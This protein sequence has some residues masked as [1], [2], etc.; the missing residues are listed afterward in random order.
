M[1]EE[2]PRSDGG[3]FEVQD[4]E[5]GDYEHPLRDEVAKIYVA[6]AG[7]DP[8]RC[9]PN[10]IEGESNVTSSA[11]EESQESS[12]SLR[13]SSVT[14]TTTREEPLSSPS[15]HGDYELSEKDG[16]F[17]SADQ[18]LTPRQ[19]AVRGIRARKMKPSVRKKIYGMSKQLCSV[20]LT[21]AVAVGGIAE[22]VLGEPLE[23]LWAVFQASHHHQE[24]PAC[25]EVFAGDCAISSAFA[26]KRMGVLRPRDLRYGDDLR[27]QETRNEVLRVV[28]ETRPTLV[29]MAPPCTAW[30]AFSRMNFSD[31][32]RRRRRKAEQPF[33]ELVDEVMLLQK[34]VGGHVVVENPATSDIWK[35]SRLRK[36]CDDERVHSFLLDMCYFGMK[37]TDEADP[38]RKTLRLLTTSATF[39]EELGKRCPGHP[40][41]R[42]IQGKETAHSASYP[43]DFGEAVVKVVERIRKQTAYVSEVLVNGGEDVKE[44]EESARG[45]A[46]IT[47]HFSGDRERES[48]W[49]PEEVASESWT[50]PQQRAL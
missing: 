50:S 41:H 16:S 2:K 20:L 46:A 34:R 15:S 12:G 19:K 9:A 1:R 3:I 36:W 21:C 26:A 40:S 4:D 49:G 24:R 35:A 48:R 13:W 33:L 47:F 14:S 27:C 45:A 29:W 37:S 44:S 32:E 42:P 39:A 17:G 6:S 18:G 5:A 43:R 31:Q 10:S 38:L 28:E 7:S 23:D 30:C 25:L 22:E 11:E 8:H